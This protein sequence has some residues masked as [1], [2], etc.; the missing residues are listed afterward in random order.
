MLILLIQSDSKLSYIIIDIHI[1]VKKKKLKMGLTVYILK[2]L[3]QYK[4][5]VNSFYFVF[6]ILLKCTFRYW[7]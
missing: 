3:R 6:S 4:K 5:L 7:H 2:N 1:F